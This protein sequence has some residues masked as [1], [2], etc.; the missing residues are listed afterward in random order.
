MG[1]TTNLS[2][3][4]ALDFGVFLLLAAGSRKSAKLP[5]AAD[6]HSP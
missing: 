6:A 1:V 3:L 4:S 2:H 5:R